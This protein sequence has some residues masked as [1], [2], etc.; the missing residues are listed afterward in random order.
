VIASY[1]EI[2]DRLEGEYKES[3]ARVAESLSE[4]ERAELEKD[5]ES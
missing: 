3:L 5:L 4:E 1:N 2:N